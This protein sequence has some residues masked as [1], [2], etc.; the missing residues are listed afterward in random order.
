M[1]HY[2]KRIL[3]NAKWPQLVFWWVLRILMFAAIFFPLETSEMSSGQN[4]AQMSANFAVMFLW[5][6]FMLFPEKTII[7]QIPSSVQNISVPFIFLTAY[8][9]AYLGFYYTVWWWDAALH[10]LGA[11]IGVFLCYEIL[12]AV[13]KRDGQAVKISTT[14]VEAVGLCFVFGVMWELLEF[15]CD[16]LLINCDTQHWDVTRF[17]EGYRN[18]F[19]PTHMTKPAEELTQ[20]ISEAA[21]NGPDTQITLTVADL[22]YYIRTAVMDTMSDLACNTAGGLLGCIFLALFPYRHRSV[23]RK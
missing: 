4:A 1:N 9:G 6:I 8:C 2:F 7:R 5:E 22:K 23:K 17:H 20:A 13:Q 16:Q 11:F 10:V 21:K 14:V 12:C 3:D 15:S 19:M 18:I